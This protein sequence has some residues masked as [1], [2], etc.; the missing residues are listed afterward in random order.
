MSQCF[1]CERNGKEVKLLDAVYE[2][3]MV[4][5]CEK[6]SITESLPIIRKPTTSQLKDS[7]KAYSVYQRL[8]RL[9]GDKTEE[10]KRESVLDQMRKLDENPQLELPEKKSFNLVDNF[11]WEVARARRNKGLSQRQLAWALGESESAIKMLEKGDLPE[12][13]EK[14]IR[15]LE[16]FFQVKIRERSEQE[17]EEE[18]RKDLEKEEFK[19]PKLE[20]EPEFDPIESIIET[21]IS[22]E[23]EHA[24]IKIDQIEVEEEP[25]KEPIRVLNF[26]PEKMEDITISDLKELKDF[27]E[28]EDKLMETEEQ[29]K[30]TLEAEAFIKNAEEEEERK[31]ELRERVGSEMKEIALGS[32]SERETIEEKRELLNKAMEK[33]TVK[34]VVE[35]KKTPTIAELAER[36]KEKMRDEKIA[37]S[38]VKNVVPSISELQESTLRKEE[39]VEKEVEN[40]LSSLEEKTSLTKEETKFEEETEEETNFE[41]EIG[42]VEEE[43]GERR[44]EFEEEVEEER[45][46]QEE[47]E[48][49]RL[50]EEE[51][52]VPTLSELQEKREQEEDISM[53]GDDIDILE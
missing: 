40:N 42:E 5:I 7:E 8:E 4:K 27:R 41:E 3:D 22:E 36:K 30:A 17:K 6:C 45:V 51:K 24:D 14:L 28:Q 29:R 35:V 39:N 32:I 47:V 50:D 18:E 53:V 44:E 9:G 23:V 25:K 19:M 20:E 2:N 37:L 21:P 34:P 43:S 33:V 11:N 15:K 31:Q 10:K 12:G 16:Q 1:R 13:S 38:D 26:K 46:E 52:E 48:E 49:K